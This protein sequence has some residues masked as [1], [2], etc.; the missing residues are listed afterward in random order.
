MGDNC[1]ICN[2]KVY[3][4]ERHIENGKL[5]HRTCFRKN[6][7][8]PSSKKL[9]KTDSGQH[10]SKDEEKP[11][12]WRR[13]TDA[14]KNEQIKREETKRAE[15]LEDK[16]ETVKT[17]KAKSQNFTEIGKDENKSK[18]NV[19]SQRQDE[20]MDISSPY[21]DPKVETKAG[22]NSNRPV[23]KAGNLMSPRDTINTYDNNSKESDKRISVPKFEFRSKIV[24]TAPKA[25][26]VSKIDTDNSELQPTMRHSAP[27]KP[28]RLSESPQLLKSTHPHLDGSESPPPLPKDLPPH[29]PATSKKDSRVT[30]N[31]T[32]SP[33]SVK[34][35]AFGEKSSKQDRLSELLE[36]DSQNSQGKHE[37]VS[38][39]SR[40]SEPFT[41]GSTKQE[42]RALKNPETSKLQGVSD[43]STK[44]NGTSE[45]VA[46]LVSPVSP[47]P[48]D[49]KVLGGLLKQLAN[50]RQKKDS[51]AE[52]NKRVT[53]PKL[54]DEQSKNS[55]WKSDKTASNNRKELKS[56]ESKEATREPVTRADKAKS[57]DFL[58]QKKSL[59][60]KRESDEPRLTF[61]IKTDDSD[62]EPAWKKALADQKKKKEE[63]RKSA[64]L[65]SDKKSASDTRRVVSMD[66][67][68]DKDEKPAWQI[69]VEK[70]KAAQQG[71]FVDPEKLK[72]EQG[73]K[74]KT[75]DSSSEDSIKTEVTK[76]HII[77]GVPPEVKSTSEKIS[78]PEKKKISVGKRFEFKLEDNEKKKIT[79]K[80]PRPP[81]MS[82]PLGQNFHHGL[83]P[84]VSNKLASTKKSPAPTPPRPAMPRSEIKTFVSFHIKWYCITNLHRFESSLSLI[85]N[86][87]N[88][89]VCHH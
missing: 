53:S 41:S 86:S 33:S 48:H 26:I 19:V 51:K 28:S 39:K 54:A 24:S 30:E 1:G 11:D 44:T 70:R 42:F 65:L 61:P 68:K 67:M 81:P 7:V 82:P 25:C 18:L 62:K 47:E 60:D 14:K 13:R 21:I 59:S 78:E 87:F 52:V 9:P 15:E 22:S 12:F 43:V 31:S 84:A 27:P 6:E 79:D 74:F 38:S 85:D 36:K 57:V 66:M 45:P 69:E 5:Y 49:P 75:K 83:S 50:V 17:N 71:G 72:L 76:R 40:V 2:N 89:K 77:P 64:D 3:L 63:K 8:S 80:P 88:T 35:S 32:V 73:F 10:V 20:K 55:E 34:S 29:L 23:S 58:S 37:D 4:L 46:V 16:Q 56:L